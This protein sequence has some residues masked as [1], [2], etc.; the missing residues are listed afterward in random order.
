MRGR[1]AT[2]LFLE[3]RTIPVLLW[4][5]TAVAL[6]TAIAAAD[7]GRFDPTVFLLAMATATLIQGFE[8][9]AI[10]E[11]YDLQ[12]GTDLY[13]SP[14]ILSGGSRVLTA[15]LLTVRG[16]WAVFAASSVLISITT[17]ALVLLTG[18]P[19]AAFVAVGYTA[20]LL[21]T[22]PPVLTSYRPFIGEWLGG[23][24]GVAVGGMGAYFAQ[25]GH[26]SPL[27][28]VAACAHALVCVGMLLV[29]HYLDERA[30]L[31]AVPPKRTTIAILGF[32]PGQVYTSVVAAGAAVLFGACV[33][34]GGAPFA[35]A[36]VACLAGLLAH[37]WMDPRD[38]TSVTRGELWII[39]AGVAG[40]LG[41]AIAVAPALWPVAPIALLGFVAHLRI[42]ARF[43]SAAPESGA[44]P[45]TA[46][47]PP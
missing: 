19:I 2:A 41:T 22:L 27:V 28:V 36:L 38:P 25:V 6:G 9:H 43:V 7:T 24:L 23:F 26:L 30:D 11:I 31:A 5:Y 20:G 21:Y 1:L 15:H 3:F 32:P 14:R 16:M 12:S 33:L 8:T 34:L 10:N 47:T 29:H 35:I 44:P 4:S 45:A 37:R 46:Q 17:A 18:P 42:G 40:G 39:E 13:P